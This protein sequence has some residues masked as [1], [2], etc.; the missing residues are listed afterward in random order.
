LRTLAPNLVDHLDYYH[1]R[2]PEFV[3][4]AARDGHPLSAILIKP[5]NFDPGKRYPVLCHVYGGPQAPLVRN[6]WHGSTYLW[7][8][9]LAQ[10]GYVIWI[11]DN[12][13]ATHKG[14][15]GAWSMHL[16]MGKTELQDLEDGINWLGKNPWIDRQRVGI[17]GWSYGGYLVSYALTHS[18]IFKA[19]IAGAPVTD[20][21]NYDAIYTERYMGLPKDNPEGYKKASPVH[22]A[23]RLHGKLLLIHGALDGNV[24][25]S[26]TLQFSNALQTAGK[27]FELMIYPNNRHGITRPAQS[28]H[29]RDLMTQF[30]LDNL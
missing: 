24:H 20:W 6:R 25:L 4:F 30:I 29:L 22:A 26:N 3:E 5:A 19:G 28:R 16:E 2:Q 10:Q 21:R 15:R 13:A 8:Q 17:W 23:S 1:V 18:K 9:Y 7:H 12:R 27:Q 14:A 11:S